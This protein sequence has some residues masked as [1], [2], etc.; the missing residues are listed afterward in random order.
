MTR[1]SIVDAALAILREEGL[2]KVTMRRV[3]TA[4]DTGHASLY[5]YVRNTEDLHAQILDA[6]LGEVS[7]SAGGTGTWRDR[8]K[9]LLRSY[10][11]VLFRYPEIARMALST[12]PAGPNYMALVEALL[13][14]LNEGGVSDRA[15]AWGVD[16]LLLQPTAVAVEHSTPRPSDDLSALAALIAT[17][18]AV[19]YPHIVRLGVEL[20]SGDGA[21]RSDWAFDVLL[22]GILAAGSHAPNE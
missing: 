16:L 17:A 5:V 3:A 10:Q 8:L 19:R 15:A 6:L 21:A 2:D 7:P 14:L 12:Q 18:D 20:I 13:A 9:A 11:S 4:L 1:Q 22:D